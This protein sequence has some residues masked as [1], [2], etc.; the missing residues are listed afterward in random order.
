MKKAFEVKDYNLLDISVL[1]RHNQAWSTKA[2][3]NDRLAIRA[4]A[5]TELLKKY[6]SL[7]CYYP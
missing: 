2:I 5:L 7:G 1:M 6:K 3:S 4:N